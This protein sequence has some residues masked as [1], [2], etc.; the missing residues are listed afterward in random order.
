MSADEDIEI[1][2][3]NEK[4]AYVYKNIDIYELLDYITNLQEE[5][6]ILKK[7]VESLKNYYNDLVKMY[8]N[9][10]D[11]YL[12]LK[13]RNKQAIE[14]IKDFLCTEEYIKVDGEA[15][16]NNYV[17]LLNILESETQENLYKYTPEK[18]FELVGD[19]DDE[20]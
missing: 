19:E 8:E 20:D 17:E 18:G 15:I 5:N 11:S 14:C 12:N 3:I 6:E 13:S 10:L 7:D 16:A 1:K 4:D 2:Y 9:R